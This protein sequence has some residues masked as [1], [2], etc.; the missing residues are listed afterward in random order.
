MFALSRWSR[1]LSYVMVFGLAAMARASQRSLVFLGAETLPL[2]TDCHFHMRRALRTLADFPRV[3]VREPWINWPQGSVPTWGPGFDQLLALP[4]WLLGARGDPARAARII[5]WVPFALGLLA[6]L[7][8][9]AV[10]RA[11]EPEAPSPRA[12][13]VASGVVAAALP[14]AVLTS[15]VGRTDHHVFEAVVTGLV[16]L[17]TLRPEALRRPW[18]FELAGALA[19]F[20]TVHGFTGSLVTWGLATAVL[21]GSLLRRAEPPRALRDA[22]VGSGGP[23]LLLGAAL[24]ALVDG[25]W[26]RAQGAPFHHLQLS[27]LQP[28]ILGGAGAFVCALAAVSARVRGAAPRLAV[29]ALLALPAA[30]IV[31]LLAPGLL[32]EL[33]A[34]VVDWLFR[35]DP[36]MGSIQETAPLLRGASLRAALDDYGALAF[37]APLLLPFALRRASRRGVDAALTLAVVGGGTLLLTLA[38]RRFGRANPVMF[39]AW[40]AL[41]AAELAALLRAPTRLAAPVAALAWALLDANAR[42]QLRAP[43]GIWIQGIHEAAL[44]IRATEPAVHGRREGVFAHWSVGF[45]VLNLARRPVLV[46]GFGPYTSAATW[47]ETEP[48]WSHDEARMLAV[49]DGHDARFLVF[50]SVAILSQP[51]PSG[52]APVKRTGR[53]VVLNAAF[54]REVPLAALLMGGSGA[55]AL[56]VSHIAHLRPVFVD[57]SRVRGLVTAV[58]ET[59]VFERVAGATLRGQGP[60][61]A[62]VTASLPMRMRDI[63]RRWE[64]STTVRDGSWSLTVPLSTG[65]RHGVVETA[66]AFELRVGGAAPV[67]VTVPEDAVRDGGTVLVPAAPQSGITTST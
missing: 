6:V 62:T 52:I 29:T 34:G 53:G 45:E 22:V 23:A 46:T 47:A 10:A 16:A 41:G 27:W 11:M 57:G 17:W 4:A 20:G 32:H 1:A 67:T 26:V 44:A 18:R 14:I 66:P 39:A 24:L 31:A 63:A 33:R 9:V 36:W 30:G 15:M 28:V 19:V 5:A 59:W 8:A 43:R 49:L 37:T 3:P 64:A 40:T 2:D 51:A 12:V 54:L 21:A 13:G 35:R 60:E 25:S 55:G 61:G 58:P 56:G 65:W 42:D 50:P 48:A 38:Q 7:L